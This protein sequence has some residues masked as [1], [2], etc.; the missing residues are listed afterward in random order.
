MRH[1][2]CISLLIWLI[3]RN[4]FGA[5]TEIPIPTNT[6]RIVEITDGNSVRLSELIKIINTPNQ[7]QSDGEA[8]SFFRCRKLRNATHEVVDGASGAFLSDHINYI[9]PQNRTFL[10]DVN[11]TCPGQDNSSSQIRTPLRL[12]LKAMSNGR[13]IEKG[14][15]IIT[16]WTYPRLEDK[17]FLQ[18]NSGRFSTI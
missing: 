3:C 11:T 7:E 12:G 9:L 1:I 17:V 14:D 5:I 6:C 10:R 13:I 8:F 18:I 16:F 4:S 2:A 15:D